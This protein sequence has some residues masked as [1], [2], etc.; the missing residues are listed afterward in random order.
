MRFSFKK[1]LAG[2]SSLL[3]AVAGVTAISAPANAVACVSGTTPSG[4]MPAVELISQPQFFTGLGDGYN[5]NYIGYTIKN[6]SAVKSNLYVKLENFTGGQVALAANQPASQPS[7]P[8][9]A[10]GSVTT[11]FYAT[12]SAAPTVSQ[13][14]EV[15]LFEGNP[16]LGGTEICR[17][18]T[19]F[20]ADPANT[21]AIAASANKVNTI[22]VGNTSG[23]TLGGTVDVT[24]RGQTGNISGSS[25]AISLS[26][27][28]SSN[29]PAA[30]WRLVSTSIRLNTTSAYATQA[31]TVTFNNKTYLSNQATNGG[32]YEA[33]Y[34]YKAVST[35]A[36][37]ATIVPIQYINSGALNMKYTG[38]LPATATLLPIVNNSVSMSKTSNQS[39][40]LTA[41][42][43][44]LVT[45]TNICY[46]IDLA[47]AASLESIVDQ[48][49][50]VHPSGTNYVVG[51]ARTATA[52]PSCSS[53][54]AIT[55]IVQSG[56]HRIIFEG[57]LTVPGNG[58]LYLS[59]QIEF[60]AGL[61]EGVY[62][63]S[64]TAYISSTT[65]GASS[66]ASI[67]V[68]NPPLY[69]ISFDAR[70]VSVTNPNA[71]T[72]SS[73]GQAVNIGAV[74]VSRTGYT[75]GGW[76]DINGVDY[77]S[78]ITPSANMTVYAIWTPILYSV[79]FNL[80]GGTGNNATLTQASM[81]AS[82]Q[83]YATGVTKTGYAFGG[84]S[85]TNGGTTAEN[86][87]YTP[88]SN[89]TV[90]AIWTA[91]YTISFDLLGG[92]GTSTTQSQ[93]S[94][95]SSISLWQDA[96]KSGYVFGGWSLTNGGTSGIADP[97]T[98]T[99]NIT[100]YAIW[101][102][103]YSVSFDA[104]DVAITNPSNVTQTTSGGSVNVTVRSVT[105]S[106][107]TFGGWSLTNGGT[108]AMGSSYT[109]TGNV[110]VYAI[111]TATPPPA[112]VLPPGP[113]VSATNG[114]TI[115]TTPINVPKP[116]NSGAIGDACLV[117]PADSVCKQSVALP[118]KGTFTL[119]TDGTTRFVAFQ[120]FFGTAAVQ[121]R[122]IDVYGQFSQAPV[123]VEV[124][125]PDAPVVGPAS[126]TTVGTTPITLSPSV[127][128]PPGQGAPSLCLVDPA[129]N[130]C[131]QSVTLP[132]KGTFT[133]NSNG[134]VS[135]V[136]APGFVGTATVQL[137]AT[138][139]FGQSSEAPITV[140]VTKPA[141][142]V[143]EPSGGT[144]LVN[145]PISVKPNVI[146]PASYGTPSLCLVDPA[147]N[148]CK[149]SVTLPGKG[150]FTLNSDGT[151][152]FVPAKGFIGEGT[153]QLRAT[154]QY[155]QSSEAPITVRVT[156]VP[157]SQNGST[158]GAT[159]V[160]LA[161]AKPLALGSEV[162]LV[163]PNDQQCKT[164]VTI[165]GAGTWT[166]QANGSVKFA[167]VAGYV[168]KVTVMQRITRGASLPRLS[169]YTVVVAKKRGPVTITISGFA[170]GSPVLTA[171]IK[172]K[173][174]AFLK[175]YSDY[176]NVTCIGYTEG[177]T[178]LATDAA[179]SKQRAV[180]ACGFVKAGLGKS[181][182]VAKISAGQDTIEAAQFRRITIT[183]ND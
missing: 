153:V 169:P 19:T 170:D 85:L 152:T 10:S 160:V 13:T 140:V 166:Q 68:G 132:G 102:P 144:T 113:A 52:T 163:D 11:F 87:T 59:Y 179:L 172:A 35:A 56:S 109:P 145:Q 40:S 32:Y 67:L 155:G 141:A 12:A 98:P 29:F 143:V 126:G 96:T 25:G 115:A 161:P 42:N 147:D 174:N 175:A 21:A 92:A 69:T 176:K 137:R 158:K 90:Y 49:A 74:T 36:A 146:W 128:Y 57:P 61:A 45:T 154:D 130:V 73:A 148:V 47:N 142:P 65:L 122:V 24:V 22:T 71:I 110:T 123:T 138:D 60:P 129:D 108:T 28:S 51:S 149:Q 9:A 39:G 31:G 159:P 117:D 124:L 50:D 135:F 81:G 100:V 178:V 121:Y 104:L 167:P 83:L 183:L 151:V 17:L 27:G 16:S 150:T 107:Y 136:A 105:R 162:C 116:V 80:L 70:D 58:H 165:A 44:T 33:V 78:S 6:G 5:S 82:V 20:T 7:G 48:V 79:S 88:T 101:L 37:A 156:D 53:G 4:S 1:V 164:V 131:K 171:A 95:G 127:T 8:V 125:K 86:N 15:V 26:P 77:P 14:H 173:I 23:L 133:L 181:L 63:N 177:P 119:N 157:S 112:P 41:S 30:A 91:V 134:T 64:A 72:Q 120:G 55:P 66:I 62:N 3:L 111:W 18:T 180:N 76:E 84:W 97:Y 43:G 54:T 168:G 89:V 103:L 38:T 106:G 93:Q 114:T 118:G 182:K 94:V 99:S 46:T 75:F 2:L 139:A 34:A